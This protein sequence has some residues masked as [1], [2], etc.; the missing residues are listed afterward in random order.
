MATMP[1]QSVY[2]LI[3]SGAEV[4]LADAFGDARLIPPRPIHSALIFASRTTLDHREIS[5]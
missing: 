5:A 3:A 1:P 2:A 4:E